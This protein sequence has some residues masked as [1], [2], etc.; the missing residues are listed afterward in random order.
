MMVEDLKDRPNKVTRSEIIASLTKRDGFFC[1]ICNKDFKSK[2][3]VTIDHFWPLAAG[4]T[5]LLSNLRLACQ[6][7]NN[8]KGD[9]LPNEDGTVNFVN[10]RER[11]IKLPRPEQCDNCETGRILLIGETCDVC[12][13]GPQPALFPTAY[14]TKSANCDHSLYHCFA[15]IIGLVKRVKNN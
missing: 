15:C 5:W 2:K 10:R 11:T 6:P 4:G 1:Y 3:E 14:K 13:S 8:L 9:A 12:G 7:C